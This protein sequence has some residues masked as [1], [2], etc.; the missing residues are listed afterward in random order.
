MNI[1]ITTALLR[2]LREQGDASPEGLPGLDGTQ[3]SRDGINAVAWQAYQDGLITPTIDFPRGGPIL[4]A[5]LTEA[6]LRYLD[7]R[8]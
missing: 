3:D 5:K 4:R 7:Q 6:G 2:Y 1:D 8:R